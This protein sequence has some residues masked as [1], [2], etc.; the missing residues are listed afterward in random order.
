MSLYVSYWSVSSVQEAKFCY[1]SMHLKLKDI[2]SRLSWKK[3]ET[4]ETSIGGINKGKS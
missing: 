3:V 4:W 1:L 2:E